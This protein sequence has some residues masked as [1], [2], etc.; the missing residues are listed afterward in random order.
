MAISRGG[1]LPVDLESTQANMQQLIDE[2]RQWWR[3]LREFGSP[4]FGE[5]ALHIVRMRE[6]L[7][8]HF[9]REEQREI[10]KNAGA[11]Q[12]AA[13]FLQQD[14]RHLLQQMDALAERLKHC[15]VEEMTW[16][17]AGTQFEELLQHLEA[18]ERAEREF[19]TT[20]R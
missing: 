19:A 4:R 12:A 17:K 18:H 1:Q 9:Q 15:S 16:D 11:H 3:E 5:M 20:K 8:A 10:F 2:W 13:N 6:A 7:A 14:H